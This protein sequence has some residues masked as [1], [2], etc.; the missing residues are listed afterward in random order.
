MLYL[1]PF[2][3]ILLQ[4]TLVL[5]KRQWIGLGMWPSRNLTVISPQPSWTFEG[6]VMLLF[7]NNQCTHKTEHTNCAT[8][9][10]LSAL[11]GPT[12]SP[13]EMWM[14]EKSFCNSSQIPCWSWACSLVGVGKYRLIT[15]SFLWSPGSRVTLYL[16]E[17]T[18]GWC[19]KPL[20]ILR[21][22]NDGPE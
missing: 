21:D 2:A 15:S 9:S 1:I 16:S 22:A 3:K 7:W 8:W 17:V 14:A 5:K 11:Q 18:P 19:L 4:R 12:G 10:F 20:R 13:M 6:F